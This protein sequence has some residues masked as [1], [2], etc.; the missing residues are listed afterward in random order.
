MAP[1]FVPSVSQ[2]SWKAHSFAKSLDASA[3]AFRAKS[4]KTLPDT[5]KTALS[6]SPE[7]NLRAEA[8]VFVPEAYTVL[9]SP[10]RD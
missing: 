6:P 4:S 9:D 2:K 8:A 3:P 1:A 7:L 10:S 5:G